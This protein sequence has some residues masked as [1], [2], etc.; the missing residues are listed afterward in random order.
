[1]K[2]NRTEQIIKEK[3]SEFTPDVNEELWPRL[4][5][6]LD[7]T[8]MHVRKSLIAK[9]AIPLAASIL[10]AMVSFATYQLIHSL[11]DKKLNISKIAPA[12]ENTFYTF[13]TY[14]SFSLNE[15][16]DIN[17][18]P[19]IYTQFINDTFSKEI[20][21]SPYN[22]DILLASH[23]KK[24]MESV[25]SKDNFIS[26]TTENY[27]NIAIVNT[28]I[29]NIQ[30]YSPNPFIQSNNPSNST[31]NILSNLPN[32]NNLNKVVSA[33]SSK[34]KVIDNHQI[35][36]LVV[37]EDDN[38]INGKDIAEKENNTIQ[39]N[40][41]AFSFEIKIPNVF[42]PNNDG[43]NDFFI[44][45][46]LDKCQSNQLLVFN[47]T[48]KLVYD[49]IQYQNNWDA[50]QLPDDVYYYYLKYTIEGKELLKRGS[51]TVLR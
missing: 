19:L 44:I 5:Q 20:L 42:T 8:P 40:N 11:Q 35:Q 33:D 31:T 15:S 23:D 6:K 39:A 13:N 12:P 48:G 21:V 16:K 50:K 46:N 22:Y 51:I 26:N 24:T 45:Q 17:K 1:M 3:L 43:V 36:V 2:L 47:K 37:P 10:I 18:S 29:N 4:K 27:K 38:L 28:N 34:I 7:A 25:S 49:K 41:D 14:Q 30:P 9:Y 32:Q